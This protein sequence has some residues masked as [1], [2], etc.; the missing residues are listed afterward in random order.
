MPVGPPPPPPPD[1]PVMPPESASAGLVYSRPERPVAPT[2]PV[3]P[4]APRRLRL[5]LLLCCCWSLENLELARPLVVLLLPS[6]LSLALAWETIQLKIVAL[7]QLQ[8][9]L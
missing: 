2:P 4:V 9:P 6:F 8:I 1:S 5:K 3:A 7:K